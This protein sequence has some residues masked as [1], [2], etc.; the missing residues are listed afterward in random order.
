MSEESTKV[1]KTTIPE[2][3]LAKLRE[4]VQSKN[5][6]QELAQTADNNIQSILI[7]VIETAGFEKFEKFDDYLVD[8]DKGTIKL[9]EVLKEVSPEELKKVD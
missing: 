5:R 9:K 1:T 4:A 7:A 3:T 2:K 8:I 6:L